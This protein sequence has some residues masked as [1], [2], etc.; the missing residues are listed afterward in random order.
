MVPRASK[1][2]ATE[3]LWQA[4]IMDRVA[5]GTYEIEIKMP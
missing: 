2:K 1:V 3:L 4:G 5:I